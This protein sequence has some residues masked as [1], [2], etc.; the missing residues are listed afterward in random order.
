MGRSA[1]TSKRGKANNSPYNVFFTR[2]LKRIKAEN[3]EMPHKEAFTQAALN[4][5]TSPENPKN[6]KTD[7]SVST[8]APDVA[9]NKTT[10]ANKLTPATATTVSEAIAADVTAATV[11]EPVRNADSTTTTTTAAALPD[12]IPDKV[13]STLPP[14]VSNSSAA[15]EMQNGSSDTNKS[16]GFVERKPTPIGEDTSALLGSSASPFAS[17]FAPLLPSQNNTAV[18]NNT[19]N[20]ASSTSIFS[21]S[22]PHAMPGLS[23]IPARN[24]DS[25]ATS[26]LTAKK[27]DDVVK[28]PAGRKDSAASAEDTSKS[29]EPFLSS[30]S[31]VSGAPLTVSK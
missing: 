27:T 26:E 5:K 15:S 19:G 13:S 4:W 3:P 12:V 14:A 9:P 31:M 24:A 18:P 2:E 30:H 6:K 25:G 16:S 22:L 20:T 8:A 29:S 1:K 10:V 7:G 21:S 28:Q 17:S 11:P 23:S